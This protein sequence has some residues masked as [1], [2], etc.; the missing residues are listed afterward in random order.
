MAEIGFQLGDGRSHTNAGAP[1]SL[2]EDPDETS[3]A[4]ANTEGDLLI[5][6]MEINVSACSAAPA[7]LGPAP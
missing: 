5:G 7:R 2:N 1:H 6:R 4:E 3:E